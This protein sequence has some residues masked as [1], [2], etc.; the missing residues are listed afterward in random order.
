MWR[1]RIASFRN[2]GSIQDTTLGDW[3]A[4]LRA[5]QCWTDTST[6]TKRAQVEEEKE[7]IDRQMVRMSN[8]EEAPPSGSMNEV[9]WSIDLDECREEEA[10]ADE[11]M[12]WPLRNEP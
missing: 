8:E 7:R 10:A 5:S 3:A 12:N 4:V 11:Q 6:V 9:T 2:A 1:S